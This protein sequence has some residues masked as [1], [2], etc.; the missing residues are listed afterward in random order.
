MNV[1]TISQ[2]CL[3][4][5]SIRHANLFKF[6]GDADNCCH[7]IEFCLLEPHV[8]HFLVLKTNRI[9]IHLKLLFYNTCLGCLYPLPMF[10]CL[11]IRLFRRRSKK[12]SKVR[13]TGLCEGNSRV[14][15]EFPAQRAS[16]AENVSIW[17][18]HHDLEFHSVIA[19][20]VEACKNTY[21]DRMVRNETIS[22][23]NFHRIT[24]TYK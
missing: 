7:L 16:H 19:R 11:L 20:V 24:F 23:W 13:V 10:H 6:N 5:H 18:R 2:S 12:T 3:I 21:R 8:T 14:T 15:G 1:H 4:P 17:C 9:W 22:I